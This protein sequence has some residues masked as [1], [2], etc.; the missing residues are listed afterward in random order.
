MT[1][2]NEIKKSRVPHTYVIIAGFVLVMA[3]LTY[4]IPAGEYVRVF[5]EA[6]G[7]EVV[8]PNSFA[9]TDRSPVSLLS[10]L[11]SVTLGMQGAADII[12]FVFIIGGSM[13]IVHATGAINRGVGTLANKK[14]MDKWFVPIF[15]FIF[16]LGGA[17]F[18]ASDE[19]VIFAPIGIAVAHALGYD[20]LTGLAAV[21]LGA[22]VGF[23][24]GFLNPFSTGIAQSIAELPIYS[25]IEFRLV[26]F[27]FMFAVTVFY[28]ARYAKKVKQDPSRS[29]VKDCRCETERE[30]VDVAA[31]EKM[32]GRDK[33]VL[34][35]LMGGIIFMV[36]GVFYWGWYIDEM[37]GIFVG[38]GVL[39]GIIGRLNASKIASTFV[40]GAASLTFGALVTGFAKSIVIIMEDGVILDT[41]IHA[42]SSAVMALPTALAVLGMYVVQIIVN[43]FIPS[44]T[45]QAA[46]IM[47][48]MIPLSDVVGITRQ[49][50]VLCFQFG[51]G[52]SNSIIPTSSVLMSYLAVS[53]VPYE[54]WVKFIWPLML[55]WIGI[56]AIFLI[57]ANLIN[58]GPF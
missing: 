39:A 28:I 20:A 24:A 37:A 40:D 10:L 11:T 7:R 14:A 46:S 54:K 52:F 36:Y 48:I 4:V 49:T 42:L 45:G 44:S 16:A 29:I 35:V 22:A 25:G 53:K 23:N 5:D 3:I 12:F 15:A 33:I 32:N 58:Y 43:F 38:V 27:V 55:I 50:A 41:I 57:I 13:E 30:D 26:I 56:G 17:T 6:L 18:G 31:M 47:P 19:L 21:V 2:L 8:D 51:D 9:Y 34:L 1:T